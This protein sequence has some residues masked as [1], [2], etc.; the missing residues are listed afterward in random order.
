[1]EISSHHQWTLALL[2]LPTLI[3][4]RVAT[5]EITALWVPEPFMEGSKTSVLMD[6]VYNY[7][8][9]DR[10]SLE[11]KWYFRQGLDLIYQWIP[12]NPPQVISPLFKDHIVPYFEITQDPFTKHRALNIGNITTSMSGLYSCRVSSNK[13]D[14]FKSKQLTIY[15]K[16]PYPF[17]FKLLKSTISAP[18]KELQLS[19]SHVDESGVSILC[20][21]G[22]VYPQPMTRLAIITSTGVTVE[23]DR[24]TN[25]TTVWREGKFNQENEIYLSTTGGDVSD[26]PILQTNDE[27]KC[28]VS[29]EGTEYKEVLYRR[30]ELEQRSNKAFGIYQKFPILCHCLIYFL[31]IFLC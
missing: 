5:V 25:T 6:C 4:P 1:M 19:V 9:R 23:L 27:I 16:L 14:S 15:G 20:S 21:V 24:W 26:S 12:P 17:S 10:D 7:T 31:L 2:I 11:I 28:E 3:V 18:P 29:L 30:L 13:G 22:Q 8:E